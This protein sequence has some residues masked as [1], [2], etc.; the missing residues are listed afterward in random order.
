MLELTLKTIK[1]SLLKQNSQLEKEEQ[2]EIIEDM[3][4]SFVCYIK[5][6]LFF[7]DGKIEKVP[8]EKAFYTI[9]GMRYNSFY[10]GRLI[11]F[12]TTK[13]GAI[14]KVW[15]IDISEI[16]NSIMT[17][18]RFEL[19]YYKSNLFA[20]K[21]YIEANRTNKTI[22]VYTNKINIRKTP[23]LVKRENYE[24]IVADYK[25]HFEF[26]DDFLRLIVVCRF[27]GDRKSSFLHMRVK[28]N[29]GKSFL[30]GILRN[31]E[32][33]FE[34]DYGHLQN[35]QTSNISPMQV[36]NS[37]VLGIDEFNKLSKEM[38]KMSHSWQFS[39]KYGMLEEIDLYLKVLFSAEDSSSFNGGVDEQVINRVMIFDIE[40]SKSIPLTDRTIY[41]KYGNKQYMEALA[42]YFYKGISNHISSFMKLGLYESGKVADLELKEYHKAFKIKEDE[43]LEPLLRKTLLEELNTVLEEKLSVSNDSY[44]NY[45]YKSIHNKV[46]RVAR[47]ADK[48]KIII[49]SHKKV[50]ETI[51]K[52]AFDTETYK[53]VHWK[54]PRVGKI[55]KYVKISDNYFQVDRFLPDGEE[56]IRVRDSVIIDPTLLAPL[57][58]ELLDRQFQTKKELVVE[59]NNAIKDSLENNTTQRIKKELEK[60]IEKFNLKSYSNQSSPTAREEIT[61]VEIY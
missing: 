39:A 4:E 47:G 11:T 48:G 57:T 5:D 2:E 19:L 25:K 3:F 10:G 28:S 1:S 15:Q 43:T 54:L 49:K 56:R 14:K 29:W 44:T 34:I 31:I 30:M 59:L 32:V 21:Q 12:E 18:N 20:E 35:T 26:L 40:D 6:M 53:K 61:A 41:L 33:G 42:H 24:E 16:Y 51:A 23:L 27:A 37:F 60:D 55:L 52:E 58:S 8:T 45:Q 50:M 36:R 13:S 38:F 22:T 7:N 46:F 9:V 17:F